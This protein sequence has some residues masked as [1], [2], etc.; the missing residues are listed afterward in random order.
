MMHLVRLYMMCI[1][2]L[3]KGEIITYRAAERDLLMDIRNGK[4]LDDNRQP[5][6]AF[7]ALLEEYQARMAY[8]QENTDLPEEPAYAQIQD[9]VL[10][11]Q[12]RVVMGRI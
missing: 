8:V 6:E 5:T 1:D 9:F 4:F 11:V 3:E 12:E 7:F 2:I 10:D